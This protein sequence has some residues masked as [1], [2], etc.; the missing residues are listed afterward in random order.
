LKPADPNVFTSCL[1][2][3]IT[4]AIG[5]ILGIFAFEWAIAASLGMR[6]IQTRRQ[7]SL[8]PMN[9]DVYDMAHG[10]GVL[11]GAVHPF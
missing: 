8:Y 6:D 11:V 5:D 1:G 2:R 10:E 3:N 9:A 7:R 4:R